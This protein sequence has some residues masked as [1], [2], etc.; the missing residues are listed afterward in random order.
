MFNNCAVVP[1][2]VYFRAT[3]FMAVHYIPFYFSFV[4]TPYCLRRLF[5]TIKYKL[6][7]IETKT[8]AH[9]TLITQTVLHNL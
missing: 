3:P 6:N 8:T 5:F 9:V 4:T 1:W 7:L 2:V